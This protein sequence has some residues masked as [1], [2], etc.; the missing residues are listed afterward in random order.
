MAGIGF[1]LRRLTR[2]DNYLG[3]L[4]AYGYSA[5]ITAGPWIFTIIALSG[6][7]WLGSYFTSHE[8][9]AGFRILVIYNFAF[10]LLFSGPLVMVATRWLAD[11]IY[12]KDVHAVPGMLLGALAVLF[13]FNLLLAV[14][15]YLFVVRLPVLE[16]LLGLMN[17]F[18]ITGVWLAG[19]FLTALK[20]YHPIIRTFAVGMVVGLG[21]N[22]LFAAPMGVAGMLLGFNFGL[23]Y[24]L[25]SLLARILAEYPYAATKPFGFLTYFRKYWELAVGG[26]VT[27][28][29]AWADKFIMWFSPHGERAAGELLHF[30]NYD[31]A[32]FLSYITIIPAMAA[33]VVTIETGFFEHY[34]RFY[35]DIREHATLERIRLNHQA[36]I[37]NIQD[38]ARNFLILQGSLTLMVILLAPQLFQWMGINY[39]QLGIFRLGA[40]G[41]LFHVMVL[42]LFI[43]LSYFDMRRPALYLQLVFL[44][45]NTVFTLV[46]VELGYE[47]YGYGYF[48]ATLVTFVVSY[49]VTQFLVGE[50]PYQ[51]FVRQNASVSQAERRKESQ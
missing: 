9:Q 18:L 24:I 31:S 34:L 40:L 23:A 21:F 5:L 42:F 3:V 33:F 6:T 50:L 7:L 43:L 27:Y 35:R 48:G 26:F 15:F 47:Y 45:T 8:E 12:E 46:T 37:S 11:Q 32:M 2:Q 51:T 17:Y 13:A 14:P 36:M 28:L 10:S 44:G 19:V 30:P 38:S 1:N 25:F 49:L 41:A 39:L 29:A 4:L 20:D 16:Q 22:V